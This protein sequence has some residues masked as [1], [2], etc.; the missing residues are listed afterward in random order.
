M[1][2]RITLGQTVTWWI[3]SNMNPAWNREGSTQLM[4]G[5]G[6]PLAVVEAMEEMER[7]HGDPPED[8]EWGYER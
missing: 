3:R 1:D 7:D 2:R 6:P 8:I 5:G 4:P